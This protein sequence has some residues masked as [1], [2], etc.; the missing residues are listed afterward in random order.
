MFYN[1]QRIKIKEL[2][3]NNCAKNLLLKINKLTEE[4]EG[5]KKQLDK[6]RERNVDS[7]ID[8]WERCGCTEFL[9]GHNSRG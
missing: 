7:T 5:L 4:N 9:C 3:M 2:D 1:R 8:T 6:A